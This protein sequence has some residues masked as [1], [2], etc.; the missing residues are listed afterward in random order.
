M[1]V[2]RI[3]NSLFVLLLAFLI[4]FYFPNWTFLL[5]TAFFIFV[6]LTEFFNITS[7]KGIFTYKYFGI[8]VGLLIPVS[9]FLHLGERYIDFEPLM[10]VLACLFAFV[11]QFTRKEGSTD[12]IISIGVTLLAL[13]YISWFFSY[14]IKI[15]FLPNGAYLVC[16]L[17]LVTKSA[18]I[19]AYFIGKSFGKHNLIP[20]ISPKKT[21]EGTLSGLFTSVVVS[22][23]AMPLIGISYLHALI[24][25]VLLGVTGQVGDLAESLLKRDCSVKDSSSNIS[26][27]GGVLDMIDSLLFTAPVFYFYIKLVILK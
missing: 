27:F 17:V 20:R 22:F 26:G 5:L 8:I 16:Y 25:G 15:K 13:F 1:L 14:F 21:I 3:I 23:L 19:A 24:L 11:L 10:I 2:R 18:D 6:A 12:H 7:S 9:V 4:I